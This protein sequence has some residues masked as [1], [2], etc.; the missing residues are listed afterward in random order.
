MPKRVYEKFSRVFEILNYQFNK[1]TSPVRW[2]VM[3]IYDVNLTRLSGDLMNDA[4][5]VSV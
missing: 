1:W 3:L 2:L 4:P 5:F